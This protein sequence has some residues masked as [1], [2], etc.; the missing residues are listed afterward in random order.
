M[1]LLPKDAK[2]IEIEGT[3]VDFYEYVQD[4]LSYYYFDTSL[5]APPEP[6]I[7]AM[8]GLKLLT[9]PNVR[10]VMINHKVPGGLFGKIGNNFEHNIEE[11]EDGRAKVV[12]AYLDGASEKA[13]LTQTSCNG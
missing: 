11:L 3:T 5:T 7:N 8:A 9:T 10:L 12:F 4:G 6:M 2:K 13:D 1:S